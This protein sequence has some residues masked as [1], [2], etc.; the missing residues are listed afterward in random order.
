MQTRPVTSSC[1]RCYDLA[2]RPRRGRQL[3]GGE[4]C[5]TVT[6]STISSPPAPPLAIM[7]CG[8]LFISPYFPKD[9]SH[10]TWLQHAIKSLS[11]LHVG[12]R[13]VEEGR[14]GYSGW[15]IRCYLTPS[16]RGSPARRTL[17]FAHTRR[18]SPTTQMN[19][20]FSVHRGPF[21]DDLTLD[22][23]CVIIDRNT[24]AMK[25]HQSRVHVISTAGCT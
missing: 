24:F 12:P 19:F 9:L 14:R 15:T 22:S 2:T 10:F 1:A 16:S 3:R 5:L 4:E 6:L 11:S 25:N 23:T 21:G 13:V 18:R 20:S 17:V 8:L 7:L